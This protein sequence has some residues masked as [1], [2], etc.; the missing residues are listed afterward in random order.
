MA[1]NS[2]V[3]GTWPG[4]PFIRLPAM[5]PGAAYVVTR[6]DGKVDRATYRPAWRQRRG[7]TR[8]YLIDV[9]ERRYAAALRLPAEGDVYHF[10]G[11]VDAGWKVSDPVAVVEHGV[12]SP[13]RVVHKYLEY[14]L[15][16]RSRYYRPNDAS[17]AEDALSNMVKE[18]VELG[19]GLQVLDCRVRVLVDERLVRR[20]I[21]NDTNE[22]RVEQDRHRL[23][24]QRRRI[25][26]LK[27]LVG[28]PA[29][30]LLVHV[31]QHPEQTA[32]ILHLIV[33]TRDKDQQARLELLQRLVDKGFILDSD[34]AP[35]RDR[36]LGL[37]TTG[38]WSG[39]WDAE[40]PIP[41]MTGPDAPRALSA[42]GQVEGK[43]T[44]HPSPHP[45][46]DVEVMPLTEEVSQLNGSSTLIQVSPNHSEQTDSP[47][48]EQ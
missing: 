15:R 12:T 30:V 3:L 22:F 13:E 21:E 36:V 17:K 33:Q 6:K 18:P 23:L 26:H 40:Y 11:Y 44:A 5:R 14:L 28:G 42:E 37:P 1:A 38:T 9:R 19:Q 29:D 8:V 2:V 43:A 16:R 25:E 4:S 35:L 34:V 7:A 31:A 47:K 24:E 10:S 20:T 45:A 27:E 41:P 32:D 48:G 39:R 46:N